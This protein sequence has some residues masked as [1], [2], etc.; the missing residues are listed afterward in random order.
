MGTTLRDAIDII[1]GGPRKGR[2]IAGVLSGVSGAL[3][4]GD[5]IDTPLTYEDMAAAGSSLGSCGFIVFDDQTDFVAVAQ[6]VSRFLAVESCGQCAPCK[7]DGKIIAAALD[8]LRTSTADSDDL[9]VVR[10]KVDTV[11][12]GAR[13]F[14]AQQHQNVVRSILD[15]VPEH[16]RGHLDRSIDVVDPY[17]VAEVDDLSGERV[18]INERQ[19]RKQPD[20]TYN[21][22]DSGASPADRIDERASGAG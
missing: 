20:W 1:S 2:R 8:R 13:C 16:F 11:A 17:L 7:E 21:D 6:G 15:A 4:T 9:D 22:T 18:V 19:L 5:H 12:V 3:L 10:S 14:L